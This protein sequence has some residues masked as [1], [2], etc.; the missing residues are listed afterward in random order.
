[1]AGTCSYLGIYPKQIEDAGD[2]LD[3]VC[4]EFGIDADDV[5]EW[6]NSEFYELFNIPDFT[7]FSNGVVGIIFS[8]LMEALVR[9]GVDRERLDCYI[10][11]VLDT[12]F[13]IDGEER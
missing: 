5:W 13:Y 1:M 10:N 8:C 2:T 11:G 12:S 7:H 3:D 4:R 9:K 6:V